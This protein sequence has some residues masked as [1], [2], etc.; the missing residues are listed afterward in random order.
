MESIFL[1]IDPG[2]TGAMGVIMYNNAAVFDFT[3]ALFELRRL[4]DLKANTYAM[5]EK[6]SAMPKQGTVS[7]FNFGTNYGIWQGWLQ[8]L[9][10][11]YEYVLPS[12]WQREMFDS[13][14]REDT[15]AMSLDRARRMFPS[16]A[17]R[18]KRKKDDGRSDGLLIAG[19]CQRLCQQRGRA[20][21]F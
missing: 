9:S 6:V 15:K 14:K 4:R 17:H 11:P 18:L 21:D 13:Q 10:I 12:V 8:A 20:P 1:G 7:T 16:V 3:D 19:Y 5:I 2:K